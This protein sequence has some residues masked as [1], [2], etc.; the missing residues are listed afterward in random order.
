LPFQPGISVGLLA[1]GF[2][3]HI[4][5]L[6]PPGKHLLADGFG[7][8]LFSGHLFYHQHHYAG[9]LFLYTHFLAGYCSTGTI[10]RDFKTEPPFLPGRRLQNEFSDP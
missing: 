10:H 3:F 7:P 5:S 2:L 9:A 6:L 8:L 1:A 4:F